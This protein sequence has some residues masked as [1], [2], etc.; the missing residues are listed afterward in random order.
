MVAGYV[1]FTGTFRTTE[2]FASFTLRGFARKERVAP[3][4]CPAHPLHGYLASQLLP[5]GAGWHRER[6]QISTTLAL[7]FVIGRD[8]DSSGGTFALGILGFLRREPGAFLAT[9]VLA[10]VTDFLRT[11]GG[12]ATMAG[13]VYA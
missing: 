3:M 8:G 6:N 12:R 13:T 1:R 5:S 2:V 4:A 10:V 11:K 7:P 9:G